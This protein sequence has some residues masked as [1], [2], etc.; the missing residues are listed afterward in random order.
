MSDRKDIDFP[1]LA[2]D[3]LSDAINL[4]PR[5]LPNGKFDKREYVALNPTRT[6]RTLQ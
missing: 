2:T 1:A 6:D 3:L 4:V 5:W